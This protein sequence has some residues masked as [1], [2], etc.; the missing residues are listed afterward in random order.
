MFYVYYHRRLLSS[1]SEGWHAAVQAL[2][3]HRFW[4]NFNVFINIQLCPLFDIIKPHSSWS[5]LCCSRFQIGV[6]S[7]YSP[8][9]PL[10][11]WSVKT[12]FRF[13]ILLY[14][15]ISSSF[16][17]FNTFSFEI[18]S[19]HF[20]FIFC[21]IIHRKFFQLCSLCIGTINKVGKTF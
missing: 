20:I 13:W 1:G 10:K 5:S 7:A 8:L 18:L 21:N 4:A 19:V 11:T 3:W 6:W 15:H 12:I 16:I 9:D 14:R 17:H 2:H